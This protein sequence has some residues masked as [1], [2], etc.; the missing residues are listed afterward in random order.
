MHRLDG[1]DL[2]VELFGGLVLHE[3]E[4]AHGCGGHHGACE[5]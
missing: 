1:A 3:V 5:W 4:F 2:L